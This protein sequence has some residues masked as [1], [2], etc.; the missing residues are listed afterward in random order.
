MSKRRL[1]NF[2]GA[3]GFTTRPTRIGGLGILGIW[4]TLLSDLSSLG[5]RIRKISWRLEVEVSVEVGR[6]WEQGSIK[7]LEEAAA[8]A[9]AAAVEVEFVD[10]VEAAEGGLLYFRVTGDIVSSFLVPFVK[11]FLP[12][13]FWLSCTCNVEEA[14]LG[15]FEGWI[16][17]TEDAFAGAVVILTW[18]FDAKLD[19]L[20]E[21]KD[22]EISGTSYNNDGIIACKDN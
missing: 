12:V 16:V 8:A 17:L 21:R 1:S 10:D 6:G 4:T 7:D 5:E 15:I 22:M 3:L 9:A 13:L 18:E 19:K 20:V 2:A 14:L 11:C